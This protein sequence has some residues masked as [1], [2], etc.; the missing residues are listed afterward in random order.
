MTKRKRRANNDLQNTTHKT[1]IWTTRT[2]LQTG[3]L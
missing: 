1:K 3:Y 2:P